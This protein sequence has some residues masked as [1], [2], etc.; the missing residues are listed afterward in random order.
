MCAKETDLAPQ[1]EGKNNIRMR[2]LHEYNTG[3]TLI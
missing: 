3:V 1:K 2:V